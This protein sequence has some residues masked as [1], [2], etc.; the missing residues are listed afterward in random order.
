MPWSNYTAHPVFVFPNHFLFC[1]YFLVLFSFNKPRSLPLS[2][3]TCCPP[4]VIKVP[5]VYDLIYSQ[6]SPVS[7][8]AARPLFPKAN[9][10]PADQERFYLPRDSYPYRS[11]CVL[12]NFQLT[13]CFPLFVPVASSQPVCGD[14]IFITRVT[15]RSHQPQVPP[16]VPASLLEVPPFSLRS[17]DNKR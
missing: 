11:Q 15:T 3:L 1:F 17:L 12:S 14:S 8:E 16:A 4:F 6:N 9:Q 7:E 13:Q 2:T 5:A 10:G